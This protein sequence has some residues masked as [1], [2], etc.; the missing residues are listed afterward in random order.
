MI[1][2]IEGITCID[3]SQ[4]EQYRDLTL[5]DSVRNTGAHKTKPDKEFNYFKC[6]FFN[7]QSSV[8]EP[9]K[10]II[11]LRSTPKPAVNHFRTGQACSKKGR[12]MKTNIIQCSI[13]I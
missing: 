3:H 1:I 12:T 2:Y 11:S 6:V 5:L 9:L 10:E 8:Q 7:A 13:R 4:Q